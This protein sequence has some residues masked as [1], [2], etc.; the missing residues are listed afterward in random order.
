MLTKLERKILWICNKYPR[1]L[2]KTEDIQKYAPE[3][4]VFDISECCA[5]LDKN[6]YFDIFDRDLSGRVHL[7]LSYKGRHYREINWIEL[8]DFLFKSVLI[9]IGVS[10]ATTYLINLLL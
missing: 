1:T 10:I 7:L 4:S 2:I 9:P 3:L 8:K 5:Y 6:G